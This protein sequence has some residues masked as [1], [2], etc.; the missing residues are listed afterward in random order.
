MIRADVSVPETEGVFYFEMTILDCPK[1][2]A[3]AIGLVRPKHDL[4]GMPGWKDSYGFHSDD[5][6]VFSNEYGVS[7]Q[8][9]GDPYGKDDTIGL[10]WDLTSGLV[11]FTKNGHELGAPFR[12][13]RGKLYPVLGLDTSGSKLKANFGQEPFKYQHF[14]ANLASSSIPNSNPNSNSN[15]NAQPASVV[16][17]AEKYCSQLLDDQLQSILLFYNNY[18]YKTTPAIK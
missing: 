15:P 6:R 17:T 3:I 4:T 12:D 10:G 1:D 8:A 5:G 14:T 9:F 11:F 13:I 16:T 7:G 2:C 18:K